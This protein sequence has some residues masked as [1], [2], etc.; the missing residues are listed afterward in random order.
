MTTLNEFSRHSKTKHKMEPRILT[1]SWEGEAGEAGEE[2]AAGKGSARSGSISTIFGSIWLCS[3]A[4]PVSWS[5][6]CG[7]S[8][9]LLSRKFGN[10]YRWSVSS[11]EWLKRVFRISLRSNTYIDGFYS[12]CP[13]ASSLTIS[14]IRVRVRSQP[15]VYCLWFD[16]WSVCTRFFHPRFSWCRFGGLGKCILLQ[17]RQCQSFSLPAVSSWCQCQVKLPF[18]PLR[19]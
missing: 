18:Q 14:K 3:S 4:L 1:L 11:L 17:T 19:H 16:P 6:L 2:D 15:W 9:R 7:R 8:R 10:F 12:W 5:C 13:F